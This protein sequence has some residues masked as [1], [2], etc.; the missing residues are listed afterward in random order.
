MDWFG[1]KPRFISRISVNLHNEKGPFSLAMGIWK[2]KKGMLKS[3]TSKHLL[4]ISP[5][6]IIDLSEPLLISLDDHCF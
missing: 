1:I 2:L 3:Q 6:L 5:L 4:S